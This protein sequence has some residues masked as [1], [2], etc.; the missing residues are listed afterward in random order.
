MRINSIN[1][2]NFGSGIKIM[3]VEN[4]GRTYLY[5]EVGDLMREFRIPAVFKTQEIEL[6]SV[7][8]NIILR[9][10]E[11]GIKFISMKK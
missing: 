1:P 7:S 6:P 11:L 3:S 8:N 9:L 2:T 10:K 5:N 4:K